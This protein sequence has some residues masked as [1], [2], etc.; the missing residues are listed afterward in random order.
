[1]ADQLS[2]AQRSAEER[3]LFSVMGWNV[4]GHTVGL[5]IAKSEAD[6][7]Y[8]ALHELGF[9]KVDGTSLASDCVH[10]APETKE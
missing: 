2:P 6:A 5:I 1:M 7:E 10:I 4:Q 8:Y 9:V 3:K